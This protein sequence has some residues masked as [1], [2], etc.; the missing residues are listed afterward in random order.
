MVTFEVLI[1]KF[2]RGHY[3]PGMMPWNSIEKSPKNK[4]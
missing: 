3:S 1:H 4:V 2:E